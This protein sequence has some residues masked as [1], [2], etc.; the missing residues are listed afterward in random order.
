MAHKP[1]GSPK[2]ANGKAKRRS[3]V[4]VFAA[5]VYHDGLIYAVTERGALWV[6]DAAT[7]RVQDYTCHY[8]ESER[9]PMLVVWSPLVVAGDLLY[10]FEKN[11]RALVLKTGRKPR[12]LFSGRLGRGMESAPLLVG[13]RMW[14]HDRYALICLG[15]FNS[16]SGQ[17]QIRE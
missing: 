3:T 9:K 13:D 5:P 2:T 16:S 10:M 15:A 12:V 17:R 4:P 8:R 1:A 6:L 7:G 11:G 14:L